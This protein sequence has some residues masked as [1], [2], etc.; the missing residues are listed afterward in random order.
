M[1]GVFV[2]VSMCVCLFTAIVA[3]YY[4]AILLFFNFFLLLRVLLSKRRGRTA[5]SA[6]NSKLVVKHREM[7][8]DELY[9][10][11]NKYC[12]LCTGT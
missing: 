6:M 1:F 11:V 12:I 2:C 7:T 3:R 5:K 4:S 8:E 10:Q 9:A